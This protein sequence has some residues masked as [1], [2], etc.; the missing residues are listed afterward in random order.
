V[1]VSATRTPSPANDD[2]TDDHLAASCHH[3]SF[4]S[5]LPPLESLLLVSLIPPPGDKAT[6]L[7][8]RSEHILLRTSFAAFALVQLFIPVVATWKSSIPI[9][10]HP[11]RCPRWLKLCGGSRLAL[12]SQSYKDLHL[13]GRCLV[14]LAP[15]K[16]NNRPASSAPVPGLRLAL[17]IL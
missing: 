11:L 1:V 10:A 5:F 15:R 4:L 8:H 7:R 16:T 2:T 17:P 14:A 9:L 13:Q 12:S 3:Q 6:R